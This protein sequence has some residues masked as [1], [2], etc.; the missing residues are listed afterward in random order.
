MEGRELVCP[1]TLSSLLLFTECLSFYLSVNNKEAA[2]RLPEDSVLHQ[3][4]LVV[5]AAAVCVFS[6]LMVFAGLR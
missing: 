3:K 5:V 6:G 1:L 2:H 4:H